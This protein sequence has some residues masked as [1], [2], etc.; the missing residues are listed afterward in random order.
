M[1]GI[2]ARDLHRTEAVEA[3]LEGADLLRARGGDDGEGRATEEGSGDN[4]G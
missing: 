4:E 2:E 3:A 1:S